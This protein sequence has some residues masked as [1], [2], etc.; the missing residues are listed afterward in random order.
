MT[1][2]EAAA[3]RARLPRG[4]GERLRHE[5]LAAAERLLLETGS[6]EAVSIR[7]VADAVGVSVPS[8]YRHFPDKQTLLFEVCARHVERL[9]DTL[10]AA[11]ATAGN[12]IEAMRR[13][14]RAYVRY[15]VEN[16]EHYR[17][18]FMGRSEVT[19]TDFDESYLIE[20]SGFSVALRNA[21]AALDAGL[22]RD[23]LTDAFEVALA[24]WAAV[25]GVASLA[26]AKPN[27]PTPLEQ[28]IET[29]L[30]VVLHG[31][32]REPHAQ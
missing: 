31:I 11:S 30:D 28:R 24:M 2:A 14:A 22:L 3:R 8:I 9:H 16:P 15:A 29:M 27:L 19:P 32:L 4:E 12:P 1:P 21:H 18:M 10:K 26:V 25:H 13:C 17:I 5:I 7:A 20:T 23:D 6:E